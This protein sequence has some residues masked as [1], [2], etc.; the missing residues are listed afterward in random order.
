MRRALAL[1]VALFALV[2]AGFLWTRDR[3]VALATVRP[4][5][6]AAEPEAEAESP[7]PAAGLI[8]PRSDVTPAEREARRFGRYDKD[9]DARISREEFLASRR[10]AFAKLDTNGNGKLEFD[11]Y[12]AASVK[13]FG[14]A[15]R[16]GDGVLVAAEFATT[17]RKVKAKVAP[18]CLPEGN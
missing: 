10:K 9:H 6:V 5:P 1:G 11:E 4:P 8:A 7:E 14:T 17:A 13:K 12:S 18:P 16:N 15:D 3:P 2:A